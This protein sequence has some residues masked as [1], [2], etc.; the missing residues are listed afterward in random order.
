MHLLH[1]TSALSF[2][3]LAAAWTTYIVPHSPGN[4]DTPALTAAFSQNKNLA[5]NAIILFQEGVTYNISTPIKFPK[6][7]NVIVSVQGNLTY[8]AD[9]KKTQGEKAKPI[10]A[11]YSALTFSH[12]SNRQVFSTSCCPSA[13]SAYVQRS[14]LTVEFPGALVSSFPLASDENLTPACFRFAFSGGSNVTL[15]GSQDPNWGW[16]NS[17]GQQ[18]GEKLLTTDLGCLPRFASGGTRCR[19]HHHRLIVH[20][21]G[22]SMG[23]QMERSRI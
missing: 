13:R 16:V 21:G 9:I 22:V 20:T 19:L 10:G 15:K 6:L 23:L 2:F 18:V 14:S 17:N 12:I 8:A 1:L 7:Q 5:T 4:D 3:S 11:S